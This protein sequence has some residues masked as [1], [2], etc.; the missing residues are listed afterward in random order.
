MELSGYGQAVIHLAWI[1]DAASLHLLFGMV[2]LRPTEL[3]S[4]P[5][6]S[7]KCVRSGNKDRKYLY[8]RRFHASAAGATEWY[9][10]A[11]G[12]DLA[13][14]DDPDRP[15]SAD[16]V[17]LQGGP[18]V[19]EPPWPDVVTSNDLHFAPDWMHGSRV[20][21]LFPKALFSKEAGQVIE[22]DKVKTK[23]LEWL[24][25]DIVDKYPEYRG[26]IAL[27]APNPLFRSIESSRL[28]APRPGFAESVAYKT[29]ARRG[30]SPSGLRL[31]IADQRPRGRLTPLVREFADDPFVVFDFPSE[32][33]SEEMSI[34]HPEH[35]LLGWHEPLPILRTIHARM[36]LVSRRKNVHV[37]TARHGGSGYT[38]RVDEV[39]DG[40]E[41][42]TGDPVRDADVVSRLSKADARRTRQGTA[43]DQDQHWFD[44]VPADAAQFLRQ[45]I[46]DAR[47][48]VLIVDPYFDYRGLLAFGHARRRPEV[49]LRIL[50]SARCLKEASAREP[51]TDAGS[52]LRKAL[53][54][55]FEV[56]STRPE[57]RVLIGKAPIVH[58]RF[59]VIDGNVWFSGNSFS[60][61]GE[62]AGM[63]VRLPDP[64]PAI[65]RLEAFWRQAPKLSDWL[66]DRSADTDSS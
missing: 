63:I 19:Q 33:H 22:A 35:G 44:R 5:G 16:H 66:S 43:R 61:L 14:P 50:T 59:L 39:A 4:D 34:T 56:A 46:G 9:Q 30:Q 58:D 38:Y 48:S 54:E 11:I 3:P 18:F 47:I 52:L 41:L 7:L 31:E 12:N 37:P 26:A 23:L 62:R 2:E 25:F 17:R 24:N 10:R 32:I 45:A 42:V 28:E 36:E 21:F 1:R 51:E 13:L 6:C 55:T 64:E 15:L 65:A 27:V 49:S 53:D 40:G 29:V 57:V 8:Y 20:H 60:A